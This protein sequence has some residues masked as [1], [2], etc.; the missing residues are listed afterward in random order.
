[1]VEI[2][3][4]LPYG[5][6]NGKAEDYFE[7]K[8]KSCGLVNDVELWMVDCFLEM[9]CGQCGASLKIEKLRKNK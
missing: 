2:V 4:K 8:C 1:M 7:I 5:I 9:N 6:E 3:Q